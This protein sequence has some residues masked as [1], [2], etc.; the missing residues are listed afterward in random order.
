MNKLP[1]SV[2]IIAFNEEKN[3]ERCLRSASFAEEIILVDSYSADNTCQIAQN[4]GAKVYQQSWLG[5]GPQKRFAT[6][7]ANFDWILSLDADEEVSESLYQEIE[8]KLSGL[9]PQVGYLIPRKSWFL[10][11][12][13]MHGGWYPDF[14][15]RLFNKQFSNWSDDPIHEKVLSR[16]KQKFQSCLH[17]YVFKNISDQVNTNDRYSSLQAD[18][19]KSKNKKFFIFTMLIRPWFKFLETYVLKKGFLDGL[20]GLIISINAA[21]SNFLRYAKLWEKG[22]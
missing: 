10:G 19:M 7:K 20:P 5:F 13:I 22:Q 9:D 16:Q 21:Y 15:L 2:V 4:L 3:I 11:R 6:S 14:Q 1:I 18:Q 8:L 12:W 17:H